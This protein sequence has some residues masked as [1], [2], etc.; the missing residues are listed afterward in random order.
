MRYIVT[1]SKVDGGS[2][3]AGYNNRKDALSAASLAAFGCGGYDAMI[4]AGKHFVTLKT[5]RRIERVSYEPSLK[6]WAISIHKS[7]T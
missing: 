4:S 5:D 2:F 1:V 6:T 3:A 7:R